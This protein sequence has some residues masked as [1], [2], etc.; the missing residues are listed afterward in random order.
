MPTFLADHQHDLALVV[1][2]VRHLRPHDRLAAADQRGRKAAKQV[3]IFRRIP[4][5]LVFGAAV[6]IVDAHADVLVGRQ[7][8]RQHLHVLDLITR[9][10]RRRRAR[11]RQRLRAKHVKQR[12]ILGELAAEID[13]AV[14]GYRA[15]ADAAIRFE[16]CK[17]HGLTRV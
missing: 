3:G 5:V 17:S 11:L 14:V 6:G 9:P 15:V 2:L 1:E 8:R 12:R 7:N 4:A 16:G 10:S 13:D